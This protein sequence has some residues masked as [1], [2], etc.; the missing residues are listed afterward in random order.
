VPQVPR[1]SV[2]ASA[3]PALVRVGAPLVNGGFD[4]SQ[5]RVVGYA[6]GPFVLLPSDF[7]YD[8]STGNT[9]VAVWVCNSAYLG[10]ATFVYGT[11][12]QH[13]QYTVNATFHYPRTP[14]PC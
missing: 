5:G 1:L 9:V 4:P 3:N 6:P 13:Q 10:L 8:P 11:Y 7:V 14:G 2:T 12:D